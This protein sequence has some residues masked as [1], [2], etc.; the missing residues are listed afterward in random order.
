MATIIISD[1]VQQP[2]GEWL[3][4][5]LSELGARNLS[6]MAILAIDSDNRDTITGYWN[7][8]ANDKVLLAG[9]IQADVTMDVVKANIGAILEAA[10]DEDG[11]G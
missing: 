8:E 6:S 5:C 4:K 7:C 11:E 1:Q 3:T 2:W 10:D 9:A